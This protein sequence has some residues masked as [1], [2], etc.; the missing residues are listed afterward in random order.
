MDVFGTRASARTRRATGLVTPGAI[1]FSLAMTAAIGMLGGC[2]SDGPATD[3]DPTPISVDPPEV[4]PDQIR[5][6][7]DSHNARVA[8]LDRLVQRGII[9][10]EWTDAAGK[11]HAEPQVDIKIWKNGPDR[12]AIQGDKLGEIVFW[13]GANSEQIW[14]FDLLNDPSTL[15]LRQPTEATWIERPPE[16]DDAGAA[17]L[18]LGHPRSVLDLFGLAALPEDRAR[19]AIAPI[20]ATTF[21]V[22]MPGRA[23]P[24]ILRFS[25][26]D[27]SPESVTQ[28]AANGEP[29][30]TATLSKYH[31]MKVPGRNMFDWPMV[32]GRLVI[33]D[34]ENRLEARIS[35]DAGEMDRSLDNQP[36]E[37]LFDLDKLTR[38]LGPK[39]TV[40]LDAPAEPS[41][42]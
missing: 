22:G 9:A 25:V 21:E 4:D 40:D 20:D 36:W 15:F 8:K 23:G 29:I 32:P 34:P 7:L 38:Y 2:R 3:P 10:L 31:T 42:G 16:G 12:I 27:D 6:T 39:K 37:R 33:R 24:L 18:L 41:G 30:L 5:A 14:F 19:V 1:A 13:T 17:A 35:I 11:R 26:G 28:L